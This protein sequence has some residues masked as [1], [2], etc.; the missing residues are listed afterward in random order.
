MNDLAAHPNVSVEELT[1]AEY[2][3]RTVTVD[4][5]YLDRESCSRCRDTDEAL[6]TAVDRVADLLADLD[7]AVEVRTVQVD[8]AAAA[9]RTGLPVSP[10]VRV[11]GRDVQPDHEANPCGDCTDL[12]DGNESVDCR[13][14]RYRGETHESAPVD[15]LVEAI[16]RGAVAPAHS[17]TR[18][19]RET[20]GDV[21][22]DLRRFFG[23]ETGDDVSEPCC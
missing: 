9:R 5:L 2:A 6:Q 11:D 14:W 16:L 21:P 7:A 3:T 20:G 19:R 18:R 4:L 17:P 13:L 15:M 1:P 8:T 23:E 22:A 12:G 10:T